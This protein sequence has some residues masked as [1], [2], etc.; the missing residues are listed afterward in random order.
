MWTGTR[1]SIEPEEP[2]ECHE[3]VRVDGALEGKT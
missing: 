3:N 1:L 2:T